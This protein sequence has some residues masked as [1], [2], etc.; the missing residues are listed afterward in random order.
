MLFDPVRVVTF[1]TLAAAAIWAICYVR[2]AKRSTQ[3]YTL[4]VSLAAISLAAC[5]EWSHRVDPCARSAKLLINEF[6]AEGKQCAGGKDFVEIINP[7]AEPADLGCYA[8][9][10]RRS[11]RSDGRMSGNPFLLP[12]GQMLEP[13]GIRAWDEVDTRFQLSWRQSDRLQL[14]RVRLLPGQL[15]DFEPLDV[16][17]I[18][19]QHSYGLRTT[20]AAH[21]WQFLSHEKAKE[22]RELGTFGRSNDSI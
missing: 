10:D 5:L 14:V 19:A 8:L 9:A 11:A 2:D 1:I 7:N 3:L 15:W 17:S 20:D 13:G 6:C 21:G 18:D 4:V 22:G 16:A 12:R